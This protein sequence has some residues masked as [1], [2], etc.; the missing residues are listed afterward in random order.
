MFSFTNLSKDI[1][2]IITKYTS[3]KIYIVNRRLRENS[4]DRGTDFFGSYSTYDRAYA[5]IFIEINRNYK[6][7][8]THQFKEIKTNELEFYEDLYYLNNKYVKHNYLG[9][10]KYWD[11][12]T[13]INDKRQFIY[14]IQEHFL[15]I[16]SPD[17]IG[18]Y[19]SCH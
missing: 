1:I 16:N 9:N 10:V 18:L 14:E 4:Q 17:G 6:K 11:I 13:T 5:S 3:K 12:Y 19:P 2:T 8:K 7:Y 15:N